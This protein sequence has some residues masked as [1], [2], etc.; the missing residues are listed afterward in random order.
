MR[1]QESSL[2]LNNTVASIRI[3]PAIPV[4]GEPLHID[5]QSTWTG[6]MLAIDQL[7][8]TPPPG[9]LIGQWHRVHIR[10]VGEDY[11]TEAVMQ[12]Y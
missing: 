11:R 10:C 7:S 4:P 6:I 9:D 2:S 5:I 8:V 12:H 1:G 3:T